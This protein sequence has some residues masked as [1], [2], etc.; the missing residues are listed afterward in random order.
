MPDHREFQQGAAR[1]E[2]LV[3]KLETLG[4]PAL[5]SVAMDLVQAVIDLHGAGLARVVEIASE[6]G[7][8]GA[9]LLEDLAHDE[10]VSGLLVLYDLHPE[11]FETRLNRGLDKARR[12]GVKL[13]VAALEGCAVTVRTDLE[14]VVRACLME[15][16]P[17]AMLT[18]QPRSH[19]PSGT[20]GFV[21]LS[22]LVTIA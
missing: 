1:I 18:I 4:D 3:A 21:P 16:A 12:R 8:G 5:R 6:A 20:S 17:D 2:G 11:D 14:E 15:T 22:D 10:V 13:D 7:E 9:A 19:V